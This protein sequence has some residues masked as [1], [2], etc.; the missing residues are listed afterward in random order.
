MYLIPTA[1]IKYL[2][3]HVQVALPREAS[4]LLLRRDFKRFTILSVTGTSSTE[5]TLFSF[6]IRDAAIEKI[7]ESLKGS[8]TRICGCFH[9]HVVGAARPSSRDCAAT[10]KSGDLW[11][12][13]SARF[14]DLNLYQWDGM[15]FQK[16]RFLLVASP[17]TPSANECGCP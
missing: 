9:S 4:G 7:A 8:D 17:A 11:L 12:I 10:K 1:Q 5:N 13:Y 16:E 14:R 15:T 2:L 6:R 3:A